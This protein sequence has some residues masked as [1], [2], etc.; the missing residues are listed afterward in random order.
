MNLVFPLRER[1]HNNKLFPVRDSK[2]AHTIWIPYTYANYSTVTVSDNCACSLKILFL[3]CRQIRYLLYET[4]RHNPIECPPWHPIQNDITQSRAW[5]SVAEAAQKLPLFLAETSVLFLPHHVIGRIVFT[6]TC[7]RTSSW[8]L[9]RCKLRLKMR[10]IAGWSIQFD[11]L[12]EQWMLLSLP[13]RDG[14]RGQLNLRYRLWRSSF[15]IIKRPVVRKL[16]GLRSVTSLHLF[17]VVVNR[18]DD[19]TSALRQRSNAVCRLIAACYTA[20]TS[21][22]VTRSE[23]NSEPPRSV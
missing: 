13:R 4:L 7:T 14:F 6:F 16:P 23:R 10:R 22:L 19:F 20:V 1:R 15:G 8:C 12:R 5:Q 17:G 3:L 18:R 11:S 21:V 2:P 9:H